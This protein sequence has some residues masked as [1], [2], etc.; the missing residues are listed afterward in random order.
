[1]TMQ[2]LVAGGSF[3]LW[4]F[5]DEGLQPG[6]QWNAI[7]VVTH[8]FTEG[9]WPRRRNNAGDDGLSENAL[10]SLA[11]WGWGLHPSETE[12]FTISSPAQAASFG[13][14]IPCRL[15]N[16]CHRQGFSDA[17]SRVRLP[18]P[19]SPRE[20]QVR[21]MQ[22]YTKRETPPGEITGTNAE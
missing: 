9:A 22:T 4:P 12:T 17:S 7:I 13:F 16:N 5:P 1:M 6:S 19:S 11:G 14:E 15:L 18:H 10:F 3:V 20:P 8:A 21:P 2:S